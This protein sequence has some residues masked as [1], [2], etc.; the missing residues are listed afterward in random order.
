MSFSLLKQNRK[1]IF[2]HFLSNA[3]IKIFPLFK[4][5]KHIII[6]TNP[7]NRQNIFSLFKQGRH[8]DVTTVY[9]RPTQCHCHFFYAGPKQKYFHYFIKRYTYRACF[10]NPNS[11]S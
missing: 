9:A 10:K 7:Q 5:G 11:M 3:E 8:K 1:K 6:F 4:R 2:F